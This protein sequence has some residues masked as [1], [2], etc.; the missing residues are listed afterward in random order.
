MKKKSLPL[1]RVYQLLETGPVVMVTTSDKGKPNIMTM[2]WLTMMEFE[3]ALVGCVISEINYSFNAVKKTKECVINIPTV[4]LVSEVVGVGNTT[5]AKVDK[6]KKFNLTPLEA[7]KVK[8]PLIKECYA[9]LECKLYDASLVKKYNFF[10]FEVVK[11]WVTPYKTR[12]KMLHH[13]GNGVFIVDGKII[14]LRSKMTFT[15]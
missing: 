10:I 11:A 7:S 2:S 3:P 4:K 13:E 9:N 5:G 8:A 1:P 15:V 12:Q 6:F 14:N